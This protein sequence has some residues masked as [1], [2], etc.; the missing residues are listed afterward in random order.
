M[1][2]EPEVNRVSLHPLG[3]HTGANGRVVESSTACQTPLGRKPSRVGRVGGEHAMHADTTRRG[4][5][6][7]P[8]TIERSHMSFLFHMCE[9]TREC[10]GY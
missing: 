2:A 7:S 10:S 6:Q 9:C 3:T 8:G 5:T 4:L 1:Q